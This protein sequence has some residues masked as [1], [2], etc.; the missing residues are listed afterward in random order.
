MRR[1]RFDLADRMIL[2][3]IEVL[4][5]LVPTLV[6]AAILFALAGPLASLG[7]VAAILAGVVLFPILLPWLPTPNF[8]TKGFI[9]GALVALPFAMAVLL[10]NARSLSWV[11]AGYAS[12]YVLSMAPVTAYVAL[13]FTGSTPFT[14]RT[15]VRREIFTYVPPMAWM[16]GGAIVLGIILSIIH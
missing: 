8:S 4:H 5:V 1:V 16:L 6:A 2:I 15:G 11:L 10:G 12:V 7:A 9:L 14:S 13:N 3:P